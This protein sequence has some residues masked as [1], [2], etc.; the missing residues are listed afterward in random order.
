MPAKTN[1]KK[2]ETKW[3]FKNKSNDHV[4]VVRNKA[5]L[6]GQSFTQVVGVDFDETFTSFA[7]LDSIRIILA[8]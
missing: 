7:R 5:R 1:K 6:V 2:I 3:L 4:I 8:L